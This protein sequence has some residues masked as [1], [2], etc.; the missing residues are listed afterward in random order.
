[1]YK[2][3]QRS[4]FNIKL[5]LYSTSED[6]PIIQLKSGRFLFSRCGSPSMESNSALIAFQDTLEKIPNGVA[7]DL[8]RVMKLLIVFLNVFVFL[9]KLEIIYYTVIKMPITD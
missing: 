9:R 7:R 6:T 5:E 3:H 4:A 8:S 1:M 2:A